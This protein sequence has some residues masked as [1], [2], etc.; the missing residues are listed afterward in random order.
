ME[1]HIEEQEAEGER[2]M[3]EVRKVEWVSFGTL[4][5]SLQSSFSFSLMSSMCNPWIITCSIN[6]RGSICSILARV[7]G[8]LKISSSCAVISSPHPYLEAPSMSLY[9]LR[10][11]M[12][13]E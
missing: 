13:L 8:G 12:E 7:A 1:S 5:S 9:L 10:S 2:G 6:T 4:T 11:R 3:G